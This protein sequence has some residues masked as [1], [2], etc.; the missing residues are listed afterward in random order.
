V[1]RKT[2]TCGELRLSDVGKIVTL[3]G[4]VH[5]RRAHGGLVFIDLRDRFGITQCVFNPMVS[6]AAH[7]VADQVRR[8]YVLAVTGQVVARPEGTQ[9]PNLPTGDIEVAVQEAEIL[10]PAKTP[11]FE[12]DDGEA[13]DE[14]LRLK[15]R[16][17]DLRRARMR[18]NLILRHRVTK[19][20]RDWFDARG[21]LEVE[22]P[23]LTRE[24]PGGAREFL[25]PSRLHPGH[26]YALPQSPQQY[27]QLLMV[28]GI[29]RYVQIARCFRDEDLRADRQPEFTQID[30]E[31]SFVDQE[32]V[33]QTIEQFFIDLVQA[34]S[35]KRLAQV[36]F[37]RLRYAD[38]LARYG[39]DKPDLR[40]GLLLED[41]SDLARETGFKV[42]QDVL[43]AGGVVKGL[44]FPGAAGYSRGQIEELT[45]LARQYGARGLVT[46]ALTA[47]G[48]R[49][50][51]ARYLGEEVMARMAR[52]LAAETGDL[53]LLV[54][55]QAETASTVLGELRL[56]VGRRLNLCD[57]SVLAFAWIV[58]TPA[59]EWNAEAG[60][61]QAKHHQFTALYDED[62]PFL[63]TNP[64]AVRAKQ[65]DIVC[66][67][68][69]LGGGSIRIHQ[70]DLQARVFRVIG[71]SDAEAEDLFGH[72]LEAFE[73]GT[74]PHGGIAIGLDRL[75]M[76]LADA[77]TI[78]EV[79]AF[80]KTQSG[81]E[82]LT[83]APA[84]VPEEA[85]RVLHIR[86]ELP[87]PSQPAG[88]R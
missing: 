85:L 14:L 53:L 46:I 44:R 84:P 28:A 80:P 26:F 37:P 61:W 48:F 67:G 16:Y 68:Y 52:R 54:A 11:P 32:E 79:I 24:T 8:E 73:Y 76:L 63:E 49:S 12:I 13:V 5:R 2:H 35:S 55:D 39:T 64:G 19:F 57:P 21:F 40:F 18:D 51:V 82:P 62:L 87:T 29:E 45:A 86:V 25:V 30:V 71:L 47:E 60:R 9:N 78:R 72:L 6:A 4:W 36:P 77:P 1:R 56:E 38:A 22:T 23:I 17:L 70:R 59:F 34:V 41:L 69:E 10:N 33:L 42:F 74:P 75:V 43:A 66:N 58:E 27:K 50:P 65:Y 31:M 83:G 81:T 88:E 3:M 7:A 15:Y 20:T